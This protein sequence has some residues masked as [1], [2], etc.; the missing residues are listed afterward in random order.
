MKFLHAADIHLDSPLR[1]LERYEGAPVDEI[2]G[3]TRRAFD[4]LIQ[5]AI[6]EAV[7][8][9]II[10][11]DV[12]DGDWKDYNTGLFF[13]NCM[14]KL[15]AENIP[16]YLLTGN[17]DAAS[18]ITRKL[19]MPGNVHT[20][21][22][23][24]PTR[25]FI[26]ALN[27]ALYG[28]GFANRAVLENIA[29]DYPQGDPQLFNIGVLHTC[30]DGKPGHDPYAPCS[31][32]DLRQKGYQYWALGHIH[33]REEISTDPYIVFPGNIQGRHVRET[34]PKGCTLVS[35]EDGSIVSVEHRELDVMRW[36]RCELDVSASQT[37]DDVYEQV[38]NAL[39]HC[40][41]EADDRSVAVRLILKGATVA[42]QSLHAESEHWTQ[43]YRSLATGCEG[44]GIW[45]EKVA[46]RTQTSVSLEE[47]YA[48]DDALSGLLRSVDTIEL[49]GSLMDSFTSELSILRQK[50]PAKFLSGDDIYDPVAEEELKLALDD[51]QQLLADRLTSANSE[52]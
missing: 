37:V 29:Q 38:R 14:H 39:Q 45:V 1:G 15:D 33:I 24:K 17:H 10:A 3:A 11:G 47:L 20:F 31:V 43:E 9:V 28:Q 32:D 12:Y 7:D 18:V 35:V 4:N 13:V 6:D 26:E 50:L 23:K 44:A 46:F 51:I 30:L 16:V 52:P 34:G 36:A 2:R 40:L 27:V 21:S 5:L 22:N 49:D 8:F 25:F 19:R 42:H 41:N 48:R